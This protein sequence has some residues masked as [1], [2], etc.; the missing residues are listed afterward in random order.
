MLQKTVWERGGTYTLESGFEKM[1]L[2]AVAVHGHKEGVA[3]KNI[4]EKRK[5]KRDKHEGQT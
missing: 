2:L 5:G 4:R 1:P 3:A